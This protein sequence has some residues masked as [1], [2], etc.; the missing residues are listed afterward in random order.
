[1]VLLRNDAV[2]SK[3]LMTYTTS[4]LGVPQSQVWYDHVH[5]RIMFHVRLHNVFYATFI[6]SIYKLL[7]HGIIIMM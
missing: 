5:V 1:M 7:P 3:F 6:A 2:N 4:F